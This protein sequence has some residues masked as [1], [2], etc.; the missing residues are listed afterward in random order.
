MPL[1]TVLLAEDDPAIR[2]IAEIALRRE[3][4]TV[5]TVGDGAEALQ[6]LEESLFDL[7]VLDSLMPNLDGLETCRRLKANPRTRQ[8][9]V[10]MLSARSQSADEEEGRE[11]GA[12][13]YIR[14]PFDATSLGQQIRQL[15]EHAEM[16]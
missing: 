7:I 8:I 13:G 6:Y 16:R 10:V 4:F 9:P 14:K 12:L 3:G 1:K 2:R 15:Y 5:Q 11:A